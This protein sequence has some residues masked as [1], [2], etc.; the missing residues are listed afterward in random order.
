MF[1]F[2][3]AKLEQREDGLARIFFSLRQLRAIAQDMHPSCARDPTVICLGERV[4][5][6]GFGVRNKLFFQHRDFHQR[7]VSSVPVR[8]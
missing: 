1:V 4:S 8:T 7:R 3:A 6:D 2:F 5:Q